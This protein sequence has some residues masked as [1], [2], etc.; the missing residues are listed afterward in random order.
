MSD[1]RGLQGGAVRRTEGG[2]IQF[3]LDHCDVP[4]YRDDLAPFWALPSKKAT[5]GGLD[6]VSVEWGV[7]GRGAPRWLVLTTSPPLPPQPPQLP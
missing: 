6:L 7:L 2:G 3:R 1:S 5:G 4:R